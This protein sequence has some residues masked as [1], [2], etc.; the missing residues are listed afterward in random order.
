MCLGCGSLLRST[1][2]PSG[3]SESSEA[4]NWFVAN[5]EFI[6][7]DVLELTTYDIRKRLG[8][9]HECY[10]A[11]QLRSRGWRVSKWGIETQHPIVRAMIQANGS[12]ARFLP[13]L[14][15]SP[16]DQPNRVALIDCKAQFRTDQP[17]RAIRRE[18][19]LAQLGL[20]AAFKLPLWYVFSDL[21]VNS[22]HDVLAS[23]RFEAG[24]GADM[25]LRVPR[26]LDRDF[27]AIFGPVP[28][29]LPILA[30]A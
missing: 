9:Q 26:N 14:V 25:Y 8:D 15:T 1:T 21:A 7:G 5:S 13:D 4:S 18:C 6:S 3:R 23:G 16:R 24:P 29:E 12:D 11:D 30:A 22:P 2:L 19:V 20:V 10:V 17:K 28:V 27:D